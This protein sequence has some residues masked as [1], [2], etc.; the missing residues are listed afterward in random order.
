[1]A[2]NDL[3]YIIKAR[4]ES[5]GAAKAFTKDMKAAGTST[6]K[7][8]AE[9][10]KAR[11]ETRGLGAEAKKASAN[12]KGASVASAGL[13]KGM[14]L[15]AASLGLLAAGFLSLQGIG[16]A[17]GNAREFNAA[18]AETSTLIEGTPAEIAELTASAKEL[19]A[20]YGSS[21]TS[22]V[23]AFYQAISAGVGDVTAATGLLDV[24]NK[25]AIGGVT[26]VTTAVDILTTATNAYG[27]DVITAAEAS[28]TL[29]VAMKAGKTTIGELARSLGQVIPIA[30]ASG[31]SFEELAAAT[32]ALTTQGLKTSVATTG[33]K[34][35]LVGILKPTKEASEEAARLGLDFSLAALEAKGFAG[36][37]NELAIATGG[38]AGSIT[39]LFGSVEAAAAVL[40]FTGG[41]GEKFS[42]TME[43]MGE[44]AGQAQEAFEK[45][46]AQFDQRLKVAIQ[47]LIEIGTRL[48]G[49][50]LSVLVPVME[51]LSFVTRL[52]TENSDALIIAFSI[53][54]AARVP[55][56]IAQMQ[57]L[58]VSMKFAAF[59]FAA[60]AIAARALTLAM[61]A[62]PF[63]AVVT[64]VTAAFRG[65]SRASDAAKGFAESMKGVASAQ[66]LVNS[67]LKEFNIER[68]AKTLDT[69]KQAT[70]LS[71]SQI[72]DAI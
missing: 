2:T 55:A 71:I 49:V 67:A 11:A 50:L 9:A 39:Q 60:G 61:N 41:A 70:Q 65:L 57:L 47:Q 25:L 44:K 46:S 32:A 36:F 69:L 66:A 58:S 12:I 56:L 64:L 27:P 17:L 31:V 20:V 51:T 4:N 15:A 59:Q 3:I 35:I 22:Q 33:L 5:R 52:L 53:L 68:G 43:D 23:E 26:D 8:T 54:A 42:D 72:E 28:D 48:G 21:S 37:M 45:I 16:A 10:K 1:M 40:S 38:S 29:F 13:G 14:K 30:V 6:K 18:I 63:V 24:A 7:I 19:S 34:A 62:I